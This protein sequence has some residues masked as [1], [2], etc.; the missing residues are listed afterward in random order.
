MDTIRLENRWNP[1][2]FL[3][4]RSVPAAAGRD[5]SLRFLAYAATPLASQQ[6]VETDDNKRNAEYL[7]H[8]EPLPGLEV[9]L[10]FLYQFYQYAEGEDDRQTEAEEEARPR[11]AL[12][13]AV[14]GQHHEEE[15]QVE[16]R[17]VELR[18]VAGKGL[19][20][21]Q[22]HEAPGHVR[23]VAHDF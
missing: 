8:V 11:A 2:C 4:K 3:T 5:S 18:R 10:V 17:L 13:I 12:M 1:C 23:R 22:E 14:N 20:V 21:V 15:R 7:A 16:E 9:H 19:A 6:A